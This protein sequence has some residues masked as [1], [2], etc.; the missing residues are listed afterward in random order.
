VDEVSAVGRAASTP[1][2]RLYYLGFLAAVLIFIG[3]APW[4]L[5][6]FSQ[7]TL[8]RSCL[9]AVVA[10]T[11]D[12]LWGYTG[13]LTFGQAT[14]FGIGAYSAGLV[15]T[16]LGFSPSTAALALFGGIVSS[17]LVAWLMGVL[18]FYP[19]ATP[20]YASVVSLVLPIVATQIIFAGGTFTGSSS[21]LSGF[22]SFELE[23]RT[24]LWISA[25]LLLV[26]TIAALR[27]VRSD[28]GRVLMAIRENEV[29]CDYLGLNASRIKTLLLVALSAVAAVAGFIYACYGVVVA[30]EMAGFQFGTELIIWTA[31]GGRATIYG[32]VVGTLFIDLGSAYLG[33]DLP[34]VWKLILGVAF[35]IVIVVMPKGL[36]PPI[37]ARL[38]RLLP[39][40]PTVR[41]E[42][43]SID[44]RPLAALASRGHLA[45]RLKS[46]AKHFGSLAVLRNVSFDARH[47]ELL[48]LVGPNGAGKTTLMRCL[49]DGGERSA[50]SVELNNHPINKLPPFEC[51]RLGVG[52][53]FQTANVFEDLTVHDALAVARTRL[54]RSRI[55]QR[56]ATVELP[57]AALSIAKTTGLDQVL[58]LPCRLL[59]H[60]QKQ[61][62]ELAMVLALEPNIILL[63]EPT[64]GLTKPERTQI[65]ETLQW[66]V[67][68]YQM[69]VVLIE[70]DLDFVCEI[71]SRVIVLHQGEIVLD[72]SVDE[73]INSK[74]VRDIYSG[75]AALPVSAGS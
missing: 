63:D 36:I 19:G 71:S 47:G 33:G 29:R 41:T 3:I 49:S 26:T 20:L 27:F 56:T 73:V 13:I 59:S 18:S 24:W 32:P 66:L 10:I 21:G 65:G 62:L 60:G 70:H 30:P 61:A 45:L 55:W 44:D 46:V 68:K 17:M 58:D 53:K 5:P 4:V 9:Y 16:H 12:L 64:A 31:L 74:L 42:I 22:D 37:A 6:E 2:N 51:V 50:G 35:V 23:V 43:A 54:V 38:R 69:C 75:A 48:S 52:R 7:N 67:S 8:V 14:F 72:G 57:A 25:G 39:S 28:A 1:Y 11:V 34:F 40:A 15:F